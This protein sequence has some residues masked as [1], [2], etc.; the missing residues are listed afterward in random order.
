MIEISLVII[1]YLAF[2]YFML[3][4]VDNFIFII[5]SIEYIELIS[6][7]AFFIYLEKAVSHS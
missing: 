2:I 6:L 7:N 3:R 1:F 5:S 4:I